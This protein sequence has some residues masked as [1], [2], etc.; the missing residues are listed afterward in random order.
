M[1]DFVADNLALLMLAAFALLLFTGYPVALVLA[2]IGLLFAFLGY[3][4]DLFPLIAFF[5]VPL[6]IYGNLDHSFV[7]PTVPMLLF[8]GVALEKSGVARDMLLCLKLLLGRTPGSLA[9]SVTVLGILLAPAAGLIGASVATLALIALPTMLAQGYRPATATGSVAAAGTLGIIL[10]PGLMLFFLAEQLQVKVG[11]MLVSTILPGM[12]LASLYIT[13][14]LVGIG[15]RQEAATP[16]DVPDAE[17]PR[18]L[19]LYVLRSLALPALLIGAV[20][21]SI[22]AG[23]ATP[24]QSAAVGA[25]G[26][27]LLI[28]INR[29]FTLGLI[30]EVLVETVVMTSMVFLVVIAASV[31]SYPFR[32]FGGDDLI[33]AFLHGL[34]FGDWGILLV[35]LGLVFLLG[36]FIDWIE[37]TVITLP[38][39]Y[40]VLAGL[41]FAAHVGSPE[42]ALIW[43]AVLIALV[44]QTSFLTPPFGFALFFLKGAAPPGVRLAD[45]Y[46]GVIPIVALQLAGIALVMLWPVLA[47]YLP[48]RL[49]S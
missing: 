22:A 32:W 42:L 15:P 23:W 2:G 3:V 12:L 39:F 37:I 36:L 4:L 29:R 6:R 11:A 34:G 21:A 10:P 45:I 27:V 35:I 46:R 26:G 7:Y 43:L 8:M 24:A 41:D 31:F 47:T 14:Y 9:I 49:M 18:S 19:F 30:N 38:I 28:V 5:N 40:P 48:A 13:F 44:L 17:R 20:L 33:A 16:G 25:L 1:L